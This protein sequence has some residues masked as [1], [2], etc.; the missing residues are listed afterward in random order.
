MK[1]KYVMKRVIIIQA[2]N[3]LSSL[4]SYIQAYVTAVS[5]LPELESISKGDD[6]L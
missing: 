4:R 6:I 2:Y 5:T 1:L 3:N